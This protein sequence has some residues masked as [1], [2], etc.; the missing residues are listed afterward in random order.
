MRTGDK[1][2]DFSATLDDGSQIRFSELLENGP[3]VVFFYPK[4]FTPGCTAQA[5]HFRDIGAEFA[6]VG[7]QRIGVSRDDAATQ[8]SF[9]QEHGLDF[10]LIADT[11]GAVSRIF[12]AKRPGG[13]WSKRQTFVV[14]RDGTLIHSVSS[15]LNMEVHADEALRA[16]VEH[17]RDPSDLSIEIS[18]TEEAETRRR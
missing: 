5:C 2:E 11:D 6:A 7:A 1:V 8:A 4:A 13:L 3:V 18:L 14:D 10:P 17:R 9:R 15:E 16:L 12:G